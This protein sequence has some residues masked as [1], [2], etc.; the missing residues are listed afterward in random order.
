MRQVFSTS[1]PPEA[2]DLLEF[3]EG[4]LAVFCDFVMDDADLLRCMCAAFAEGFLK[5]GEGD[6]ARQL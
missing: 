2:F 1:N 5:E 6:I 4:V 3:I